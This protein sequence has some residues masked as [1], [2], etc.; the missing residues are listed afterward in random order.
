MCQA[1]CDT[2]RNTDRKAL[3]RPSGI[4]W[5]KTG[6]E[7]K[8]N[9]RDS[10]CKPC[11]QRFSPRVCQIYITACHHSKK[12]THLSFYA[13][14]N[15]SQASFHKCC[16]LS[17]LGAPLLHSR[18]GHSYHLLSSTPL[19]SQSMQS[20]WIRQGLINCYKADKHIQEN[21]LLPCKC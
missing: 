16:L 10:E 7:H 21:S 18:N 20:S 8:T 14:K 4:R 1:P 5:Q 12:K 6:W 13:L 3:P 15:I 19:G 9:D 17:L 2:V 11:T